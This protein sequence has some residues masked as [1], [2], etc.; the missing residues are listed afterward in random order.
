MKVITLN[1]KNSE[2]EIIRKAKSGDRRAQ[3][4]VYDRYAPK[5]L[6]VC[7]MYIK[8]FHFAEDV[9]LKGF[10]KLFSGLNQYE[11]KGSFEGWIRRIM[12]R[13]AIDFLRAGKQ[14]F[15]PEH[16]EDYTAPETVWKSDMEEM[17]YIQQL[18]DDLPRGYK[19]VFVLSAIEGYKHQEIAEM[20]QISEGTSKSQLSK[21]RKLLQQKL[22]NH[23]LLN[24]EI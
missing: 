11:G 14:L 9:L 7:K 3:K 1:Y 6:S 18:I 8:D 4:A 24:Y 13:E 2:Q 20:L 16:I 17:D 12:V 15:L 23:K 22:S 19:V 21:A 10:F 5:M